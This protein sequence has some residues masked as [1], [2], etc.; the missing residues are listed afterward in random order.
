MK[1][2]WASNTF[3]QSVLGGIEILPPSPEASVPSSPASVEWLE[4]LPHAV[5]SA[6]AILVHVKRA[7]PPT[8]AYAKSDYA[9]FSGQPDARRIWATSLHESDAL[10]GQGG[11]ISAAVCTLM[12]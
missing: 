1:S 2:E 11:A 5:S 8:E 7:I 9:S 6:T 12:L 10:I 3:A 4:S